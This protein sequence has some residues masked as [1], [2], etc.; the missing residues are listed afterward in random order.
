MRLY[1]TIPSRDL[2]VIGAACKQ[3]KVQCTNAAPIVLYPAG[4][5]GHRGSCKQLKVQSTNA[6][7]S[8]IPIAEAGVK[9]QSL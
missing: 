1:S 4:I 3:L 6:A 8:A 9:K 5:Q 2:G 7:P